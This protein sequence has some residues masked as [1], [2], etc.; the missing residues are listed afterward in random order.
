MTNNLSA[1]RIKIDLLNKPKGIYFIRI[2]YSNQLIN[3][4]IV[5]Q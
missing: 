5:L 1:E 3:H 2:E 4:K